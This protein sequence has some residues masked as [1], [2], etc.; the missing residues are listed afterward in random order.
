MCNAQSGGCT[1]SSSKRE[2]INLTNSSL[3]ELRTGVN[4]QASRR[5]ASVIRLAYRIRIDNR[6]SVHSL[7]DDMTSPR[8]R[9]IL[10]ASGMSGQTRASS[11]AHLLAYMLSFLNEIL[12]ISESK[13]V[14]ALALFT[15][16]LWHDGQSELDQ[17]RLHH[18][19]TLSKSDV[20]E[21]HTIHSTSIVFV[22]KPEQMRVET[23]NRS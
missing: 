6:L 12:L 21:Y 9:V 2:F 19:R 10:I 1:L 22:S 20:L 18:S 7:R 8:S 13:L 16:L 23:I 5:R 17:R 14:F 4:T 3:H 11:R 15:S